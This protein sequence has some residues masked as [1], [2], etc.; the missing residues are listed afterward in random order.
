MY[1]LWGRFPLGGT[2][3]LG[4][5]GGKP[6]N[7]VLRSLIAEGHSW[8]KFEFYYPKTDSQRLTAARVASEIP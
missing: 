8:L 6:L 1:R 3:V 2:S 4:N 5:A 7:L